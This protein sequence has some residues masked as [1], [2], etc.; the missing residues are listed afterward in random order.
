[1]GSGSTQFFTTIP[2]SDL[3]DFCQY[4]LQFNDIARVGFVTF[5]QS[6]G[7]P[8]GGHISAQLATIYCVVSEMLRTRIPS[9]RLA[10]TPPPPL[11]AMRYMDNI[12]GAFNPTVVSLTEIQAMLEFVYRIPVKLEQAGH[13]LVSLEMSVV[14]LP[15][16]I[17]FMSKPMLFDSLDI[18]PVNHSIVRIPPSFSPSF[19][20]FLSIYVPAAFM[21]CFRY[22]SHSSFFLLAIRNL[23]YGLTQHGFPSYDVSVLLRRT[24]VRHA[25]ELQTLISFDSFHSFLSMC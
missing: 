11:R 6:I 3:L 24:F 5:K 22:A 17:V 15:T 10:V 4:E 14:A 2:M 20:R 7:V 1:M 13:F 18:V 12:A 8:M 16:G 21:K 25:S 19:Q 9:Y 23:F